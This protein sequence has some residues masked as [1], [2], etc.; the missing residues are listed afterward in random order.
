MEILFPKNSC[1][2]EAPFYWTPNIGHALFLALGIKR[3]MSLVTALLH[4][5]S[6]AESLEG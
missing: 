4:Y 5:K 2:Y 1:I 3:L 6:I